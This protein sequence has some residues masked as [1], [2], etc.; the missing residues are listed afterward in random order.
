L[1]P[2]VVLAPGKDLFSKEK[3]TRLPV[4]DDQNCPKYVIHQATVLRFREE[5][6]LEPHELQ[7]LTLEILGQK[8]PELLDFFR[9]SFATVGRESSLIDAKRV[10]DKIPHC[11]DVFI[12]ED[13]TRNSPVL[14]WLTNTRIM[15]Q[16]D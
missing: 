2:N 7:E 1:R 16:L 6:Q 13:G 5:A 11:R 4:F 8:E 10:L 3:I 14:G 15:E 12:T 9:E